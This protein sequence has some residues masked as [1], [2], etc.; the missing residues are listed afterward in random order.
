[1]TDIV[2]N[3]TTLTPLSD[4]GTLQRGLIAVTVLGF[5]SF[6]AS[7]TLFLRL[8]Y[9][10][11]TWT[12]KTKSRTNQFLILIFNLVLADIQ[13][14]V[15]FLLNAQWLRDNAITIS[16]ST[17]WAQGWFVSTGDL[18]SGLFTL[19]IAMHSFLD[20]VCNYRLG[21][22]AFLGTIA[23]L[24]TFDYAL[25]IIGIGMH[26]TNFYSRAGAWCWI[27]TKYTNERLWLHYF[28]VIIAEFGTVTSYVLVL[29]ILWKRVRESFYT[30]S[31]TEIRA[32]SAG[33]LIV[34]YPIVYVVC[35]LPLVKARLTSMAGHSVSFLEL[36]VAG[37][38]ITSCGWLDVLLYSLTRRALLFG[39]DIADE[40]ARA[41][42]TFR[43]R[44]DQQYGTT[45]FIEATNPPRSLNNLRRS[46]SKQRL[47]DRQDDVN[48]SRSG[49][50]EELFA[51]R[52]RS[53]QAV[54]AETTVIVRTDALELEPMPDTP[55][56]KDGPGSTSFDSR[57]QK[58]EK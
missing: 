54:K 14:S 45:T 51:S 4:H 23:A 8:A 13:Q 5:L 35:T 10:L 1:M 24:W 18:G 22:K 26:P 39:P 34:A 32:R 37:S 47:H 42:D 27:D 49:S 58:S 21:N 40:H 11:I 55:R 38:M 53:R 15:A 56:L 31:S 28:W 19:A 57:S 20:I 6:I 48:E 44:P 33:K 12:R 17:C 46:A 3:P 25:A 16:T 9:K 2:T 43:L 30:T 7:I 50:T 52:F 41:L 36:T 29:L